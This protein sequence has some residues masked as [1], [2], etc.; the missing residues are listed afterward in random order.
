[1]Q[2]Q[3]FERLDLE[4]GYQSFGEAGVAL[5]ASTLTPAQYHQ[6]VQS[7]TPVLGDG[8]YSGARI[9]LW[10]QYGWR[11]QLP[12][13]MIAWQS[14]IESTL[15]GTTLRSDTDGT[16]IYYGLALQYLHDAHW[17]AGIAW[18][19][20]ALEPENVRVIQLTASYRF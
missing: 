15:N 8:I 6:A 20:F 14:D 7:L 5:S 11:L 3:W 13:G 12:L 10:Q 1:V 2:Y 19:Q 18:Q 16:D 9:G 4:L 17:S